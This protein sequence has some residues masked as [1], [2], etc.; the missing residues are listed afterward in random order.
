MAEVVLVRHG[1]TQWSRDG[2]HTGSSDIPL[3][4]DGEADARALGARLIAM[5]FAVRRDLPKPP[6]DRRAPPTPRDRP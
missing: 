1:Q 2:R 5:R 4:P 3:L 6:T